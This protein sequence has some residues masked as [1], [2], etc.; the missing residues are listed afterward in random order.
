[1]ENEEI[2]ECEGHK[3]SQRLLTA[4]WLASLESDCSQMHSRVSSDWLPSYIKV[5]WS[6]LEIFKMVGYFP[7]R[8]HTN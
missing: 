2:F 1:L 5:T 6:V 7:D 3:L 4:D 8:F